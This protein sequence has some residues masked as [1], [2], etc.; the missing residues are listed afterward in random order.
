MESPHSQTAAQPRSVADYTAHPSDTSSFFEHDE[1][2]TWKDRAGRFVKPWKRTK[3]VANTDVTANVDMDTAGAGPLGVTVPDSVHNNN[4]HNDNETAPS[5]SSSSSRPPRRRRYIDGWVRY[6]KNS[7]ST[8]N[9]S[10]TS[11]STIAPPGK[12]KDA[13]R[14]ALKDRL[15][16]KHLV[17]CAVSGLLL[18]MLISLYLVYAINFTTLEG[19][20]YHIFFILLIMIFAMVF[21]HSF[22]RTC[23]LATKIAR[24]GSTGLHRVPSVVG[25]LGYAQPAH[26]IHVV[27]A[28]DEE[29]VIEGAAADGNNNTSAATEAAT[30]LT[31]PPPAYG[32]W[33]SSV[34]INPNLLYWQRVDN[35]PK[36]ETTPLAAH[37]ETST[38]TSDSSSQSSSSSTSPAAST[39][40]TFA[41][42]ASNQPRPP[43]YASDD[44]VQGLP[45]EPKSEE[46][47]KAEIVSKDLQ[48]MDQNSGKDASETITEYLMARVPISRELVELRDRGAK[49]H[50]ADAYFANQRN[51]TDTQTHQKRQYF[52]D[53]MQ[54]MAMEM[55][56]LSGAWK[57]RSQNDSGTR[58]GRILDLSMA[59][60]GLLAVAMRMNPGSEAVAFSLST[61]K[62][63]TEI[64]LESVKGFTV[65][66][67]GFLD[68]TML[69]ADMEVTTIPTQHP[70]AGN[71]FT[72]RQLAE[73]EIFDLVLCDGQGQLNHGRAS[74]REG[75]KREPIRLLMSEL[76]LDLE[77]LRPGGTMIF[78]LH[79]VDAWETV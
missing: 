45:Q 40:A 70:D 20:T 1:T 4:N 44:G 50:E 74:Y 14:I 77:H 12:I 6:P 30:K 59:P 24:Y 58:S 46:R 73:T 49:S 35:A 64:L 9:P 18:L 5:A 38:S 41:T 8:S 36:P 2:K 34:R 61:S 76:V 69:A 29:I 55:Q 32:L 21:C 68:I 3:R 31:A 26:P 66:G 53:K 48:E 57:I 16:R 78:L 37:N 52:F 39:A 11:T 13:Y 7:S 63:G 72:K 56:Y 22:A 67:T 62:G 33:R 27:L 75:Q 54:K 17:I 47:S 79:K 43:S 51:Q 28:R 25:P 71:F 15:V 65:E 10:S 60:G 19:Q 42:A 23:L